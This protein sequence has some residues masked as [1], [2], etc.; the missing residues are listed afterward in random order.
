MSGDCASCRWFQPSEREGF[1][2][3]YDRK[4][5]LARWLA[6]EKMYITDRGWTGRCQVKPQPV[7]VSSTYAC[8]QWEV[9]ERC[10]Y[11]ISAIARI[12]RARMESDQLYEALKAERK[13][14]R[15]RFREVQVL[16]KALRGEVAQLLRDHGIPARR[17]VQYAGGADSPDVIGLDGVHIEV[18][19]SETLALYPAMEQALTDARPGDI[20]TVWHRRS[21]RRW[22]VV[23]HAEDFL[24][25]LRASRAGSAA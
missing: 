17:G 11:D 10:I 8:A 1:A 25:V 4:T 21:G 20:A 15:A 19:R 22:V 5:D 12:F 13:R 23:L 9:D 7:E 14:S 18:K 6:K 16:R 3:S 24:A 2:S